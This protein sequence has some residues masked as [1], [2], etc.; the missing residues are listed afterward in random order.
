[1]FR[2]RAPPRKPPPPPPVVPIAPPGRRKSD[3]GSFLSSNIIDV[4]AVIIVFTAIWQLATNQQSLWGTTK[5]PATPTY[6]TPDPPTSSWWQSG[7][8]T[9][10][11]IHHDTATQ[12]P[13]SMWGLFSGSRQ[14]PAPMTGA[15]AGRGGSGSPITE[16]VG[17]P[18]DG[19][20]A[21]TSGKSGSKPTSVPSRKPSS[22]SRK[23]DAAYN[24]KRQG[25]LGYF[26][27]AEF[28]PVNGG[29]ANGFEDLDEED[30]G[31][32]Q[33]LKAMKQAALDGSKFAGELLARWAEADVLAS[34]GG[35]EEEDEDT[36]DAGDSN[37]NRPSLLQLVLSS[38]GEPDDEYDTGEGWRKLLEPVSPLIQ[39]LGEA[40][41]A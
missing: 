35:V 33:F 6:H 22:S 38:Q 31:L 24:G 21:K 8:T 17:V 37:K 23:D 28:E 20:G 1:M 15:A 25:L 39:S 9:A 5:P 36:S 40:A 26:A 34:N 14:D 12:R 29:A 10:R 13:R 2:F 18:R 32:A 11:P 4:L 7:A 16:P 19:T 41:H 3:L 30:L 27:R